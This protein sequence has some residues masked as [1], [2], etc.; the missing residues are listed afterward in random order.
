MQ[1]RP[2]TT[3]QPERG[4]LPARESGVVI[5]PATVADVPHVLPM[6]RAICDL[7]QARDPERFRVLPD[8]L[9]RYASWLPERALDPRS[10]FVVAQEPGAPVL[11]GFAVCT[12]EPE[13]PIFWVPECGWIH[14]LWVEPAA[15]RRGIAR[16]IVEFIAAK[17]EAMGVAQIRL[18]TAAF[19]EESRALFKQAGFR[20]CVVEM[21]RT[22]GA[23]RGSDPRASATGQRDLP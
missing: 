17:F 12:I 6:V 2:T 1:T 21:L 5:R 22:L 8:V 23:S 14:D 7:H 15:R 20:P 13:V 16:A 19:N 11:L 4:P 10:V 3:N 18:H 9:A